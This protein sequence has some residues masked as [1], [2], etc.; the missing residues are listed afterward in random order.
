MLPQSG[1]FA[2]IGHLMVVE[3]VS[4]DNVF[5]SQFNFYGS[6]QYSTMW[7]KTSRC[8]IPTLP[9]LLRLWTN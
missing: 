7:I 5:V 9:S 2:P 3:S 4:G 1:A 6:G 8:D